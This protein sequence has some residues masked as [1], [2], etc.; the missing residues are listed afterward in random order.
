VSDLAGQYD[1]DEQLLG[2]DVAQHGTTGPSMIHYLL[3]AP[4]GVLA[5]MVVYLVYPEV[6]HW[7][8]FPILLT[9]LV[10]SPVVFTWLIGKRDTFDPLALASL[11]MTQLLVVTPI[12]HLVT[13]NYFL[14][15]DYDPEGLLGTVS[16]IC[17]LTL[18][19]F[20]LG[21]KVRLGE[22]LGYRIFRKPKVVNFGRLRLV[23]IIMI[24]CSILARVYAIV[25]YGGVM[26]ATFETRQS[27]SVGKGVLVMIIDA[28]CTAL[29]LWFTYYIALAKERGPLN[30]LTRSRI[31]TRALAV[32]ALIVFLVGLRGSR[33]LILSYLL[34]LGGIYHFLVKRIRAVTILAI[35]VCILPLL[36]G[37][38]MYKLYGPG[39]LGALYSAEIRK[40]F[41]QKS[42]APTTLIVTVMGDLGRMHVWMYVKQEIDSNRYPMQFGRTYLA[43]ALGVIP[44]IIWPTRPFGMEEV[45]TD[46]RAGRGAWKASLEKSA[47]ITGI[48]GESYANFGIIGPFIG[49]FIYGIIV[50]TL[51]TVML[52]CSDDPLIVF[53]LPYTTF[54]V[55][56]FTG[57]DSGVFFHAVLNTLGPAIL[58]V[59]LSRMETGA[60]QYSGEQIYSCN[61]LSI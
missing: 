31:L 43:A 51:K 11:Y 28:F 49:M 2:A 39:A 34:W 30:A 17:L 16:F 10:L 50:R 40:E 42:G 24:S 15:I 52:R 35:F 18:I 5:M 36:H 21:Y 45:I 12:M 58:A 44:H 20:F 57:N 32:V 61:E 14:P 59:W 13:R 19:P 3:G 47:M 53:L 55:T 48:F 4:I 29:I 9:S 54:L 1:L 23:I 26:G 46:M 38:K 60:G 25:R 7:S 6:H 22:S 33:S 56:I 41:E 37:Y 27:F 8:F